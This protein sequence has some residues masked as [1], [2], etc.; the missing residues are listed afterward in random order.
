MMYT[1]SKINLHSIALSIVEFHRIHTS[2]VGS[3]YIQRYTVDPWSDL[4]ESISALQTHE[5]M[6]LD[7]SATD[8]SRVH[9][10]C[11]ITS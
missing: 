8:F 11:I 10:Q 4:A 1:I 5:I 7:V 3:S 2:A 6:N 9:D